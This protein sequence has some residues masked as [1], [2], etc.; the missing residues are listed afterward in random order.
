MVEAKCGFNNSPNVP[1]CDLLIAHGPSLLVD[2]G[3]DPAHDPSNKPGG[4]PAPGITGV[5]ALVDTGATECCIDSLL[6]AHLNLP[7]VNKRQIAGIGGSH[8][9]N[10]YLAQV[11]VPA[12]R[13]TMNGAFAGVDLKACGQIHSAL[14]GRTF[15]RHFKMIYHHFRLVCRLVFYCD[16]SVNVTSGCPSPNG[17]SAVT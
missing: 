5:N 9:V 2:I 13:V 16:V 8:T 15:L 3:F 14:I 12:L 6:A 11:H 10:V 7:I 4:V 17:P 1:G